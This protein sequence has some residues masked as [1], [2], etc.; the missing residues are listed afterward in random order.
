M[1]CGRRE[2]IDSQ[3]EAKTPAAGLREPIPV[4][5]CFKALGDGALQE[6]EH[7]LGLS[8]KMGAAGRS[9]REVGGTVMW[10]WGVVHEVQQLS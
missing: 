5:S 3:V 7:G 8:S 6:T 1:F 10:G 2:H 9:W 4:S